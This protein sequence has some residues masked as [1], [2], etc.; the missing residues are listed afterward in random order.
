V[1]AAGIFIFDK[2]HWAGTHWASILRR[3]LI[4][5]VVWLFVF[6]RRACGK[7]GSQR[8]I[9]AWGLAGMISTALHGDAL[10]VRAAHLPQ[11]G[12]PTFTFFELSTVHQL[13]RID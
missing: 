4:L 8:Y 10:V 6:I 1:S 5:E 12:N 9:F 11:S 7:F 3:C 13:G 2:E